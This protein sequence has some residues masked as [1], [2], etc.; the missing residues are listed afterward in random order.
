MKLIHFGVIACFGLLLL[1]SPLSAQTKSPFSFEEYE[2]NFGEVYENGGMVSTKFY[3][4]NT[5]DQPLF[6][7]NVNVSCGCTEPSYSKDTL[8]PG[9]KSYITARFD[10]TGRP[11]SFDKAL[12][13][14]FNNNPGFTAHLKIK[15]MVISVGQPQKGKYA[16]LYGN[17]SLSNTTFDF[18]IIQQDKEYVATIRISNDGYNR[19]QF[20][21]FQNLPSYFKVSYPDFLN[22]GDTGVITLKTTKADLKD[23]WGE[24]SF[25]LIMLSNDYLMSQKVLY[26]KGKTVQDFS[27]LS[28]KELANAPVIKAET[29]SLKFGKLKLGGK[30][31]KT[32]TIT[33]KG[34]SNLEIRNIH[35]P[36]YCF[37]GEIDKTVI[38]PGESATLTLT[39]DSIGQHEGKLIRGV[40][41][42]SNDPKNPEFGVYGEVEIYKD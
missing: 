15:G 18:G 19:V 14:T 20:L 13:V 27:H 5:G 1:N 40:M 8:K 6:I 10:P 24:F 29:T 30:V 31:S 21:G 36:C 41:I 39:F 12:T 16:F 11:G 37:K 3:F 25:R 26:V 35:Y 42:Y 22:S 9:E 32:I 23:F 17:T 28:K 7:S 33:N 2:H 34:K 38:P 4:K